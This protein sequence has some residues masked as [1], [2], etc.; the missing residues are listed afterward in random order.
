MQM[1]LKLSV[2]FALLLAGAAVPGCSAGPGRK[3]VPA[4]D[5]TPRP[6]F[7]R[8]SFPHDNYPREFIVQIPKNYKPGTAYPVV[9][10]FH[11]AGRTNDDWPG[12]LKDLSGRAEFIGIYPQGVLHAWEPVDRGKR[13]DD[14][15]FTE[16]VLEWLG[17][18]TELD[19]AKIFALGW[20]LGGIFCNKL[21]R[22]SDKF[23]ALAAISGSFYENPVFDPRMPR[24]SVLLIHGEQDGVIPFR[25]GISDSGY[26]YEGASDAAAIWAGHDGCGREPEGLDLGREDI[27]AQRYGGCRDSRE[28]LLF[29]IP[30]GG[31]HL[32]ESVE[33]IFELVWDFFMRNGRE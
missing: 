23:A 6:G 2:L 11:G 33:G 19:P 12:F 32:P 16:A 27:T 30:R 24:P 25:G 28:V 5:W 10:A 18:R 31:H 21:G 9:F 7:A 29:R 17:R 15:G 13:V 22:Y 4:R 3:T 20:S 26:R 8:L 14:V 1:N